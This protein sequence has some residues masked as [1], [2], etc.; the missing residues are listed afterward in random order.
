VRTQK[1][2]AASSTVIAIVLAVVLLFLVNYLGARHYVRAD[3]TKSR[4][5]SLSDKTT[6]VLAALK[7]PVQVVVFMTPGSTLFEQTKELLE[8]YRAKSG[9]VT[10]EYIDPDRDPLRTRTLVDQYG[11]AQANTVVF[12]AGERKKYVTSDQLADYDYSGAQFGQSPRMTGFKGEEQFTS[13]I[14]G[15]VN[16]KVPKIYFSTGHGEPELEGFAESGLSQFK[17]LLKRDNL[18]AQ[19]ISLLRGEVPADCD[20]LVTAG[21][22]APF[23]EPEKAAIEAYLGRGGRL[24]LLLDPL[25]G[26]AQRGSGLETLVAKYGIQFTD[27]LV[28]DP[29]RALPF[30]DASMVYVSDFRA[31]PVSD[32]MRGLAVVLPVA[33]SVSTATAEGASASI[34]LTTSAGGWGER[35]IAGLLARKPIKR[36]D[37]DTQGPVSLGVAAQSEQDKDKGFRIVAFGD[38]DFLINSQIANVGNVNLGLNAVN[39][40]VRREEALGIAPRQPEQVQLVLS[41]QQMTAIWVLSIVVLPLAAIA[42]G[43]TVWWRRRR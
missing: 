15:V 12:V 30:V 24:L 40:L 10:V 16:P 18:E 34:L 23:A 27:D 39:W 38:S 17:E 26:M 33:R 42:L 5:Y 11:V 31:H 2:W 21:P 7:E 36:D 3:W 37:A 28:I 9:K 14:L 13:A 25:L 22:K 29:E 6:N 32:A 4:I 1:V 41:Q 43:V 20:L 8:R 35:D 19:T